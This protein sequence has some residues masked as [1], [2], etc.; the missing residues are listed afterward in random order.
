MRLTSD[1]E[2]TSQKQYSLDIEVTRQSPC[3]LNATFALVSLWPSSAG[4]S[5]T[6]APVRESQT[7]T[8]GWCRAPTANRDPS[9]VKAP[10][11][12]A[13]WIIVSASTVNESVLKKRH[14]CASENAQMLPFGETIAPSLWVSAV[15]GGPSPA[16]LPRDDFMT[17]LRKI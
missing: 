3:G 9:G 17:A 16:G 8:P 14:F 12:T 11:K 7:I 6:N 13:G 2:R 1:H 4:N 5:L 10:A 15:S